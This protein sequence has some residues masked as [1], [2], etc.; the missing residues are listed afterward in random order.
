MAVKRFLFLQRR[1]PL[2][3]GPET[4]D[5][6]LTAAAFDQEVHLAFLDDG[7][8]CLLTPIAALA[9]HP[10]DHVWVERQSLAERGLAEGDLT[11]GAAP[12]DRARLAAL[13]AEMD[14]VVSG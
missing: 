6:P 8:F 13:M 12:I 2:G 14:V 9:D 1:A 7:V 4:L 5:G 3:S 10:L 11:V